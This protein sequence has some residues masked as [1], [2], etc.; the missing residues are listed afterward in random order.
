MQ[1]VPDSSEQPL[2]SQQ[3]FTPQNRLVV[4]VVSSNVLQSARSWIAWAVQACAFARGRRVP[5][6][7]TDD[8][9][10][11]EQFGIFAEA[12]GE[13][14]EVSQAWLKKDSRIIGAGL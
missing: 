2:T 8:W 14:E 7:R 1:H 5:W 9:P 10:K 11:T 13:D 12:K 3:P 6:A 4:N